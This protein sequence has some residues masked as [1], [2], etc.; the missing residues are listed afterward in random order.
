MTD[1]VKDYKRNPEEEE[2][3]GKPTAARF[4][5]GKIRH[6]L[7]PPWAI[8]EIAKVYT[9]GCK[10]YDDDNWRKGMKWKE[11]VIGPLE[12]HLNKWLRGE[13]IDDESNCHHLAMVIWQ[14]ICLMMYEKYDLGQDDRNPYDLDMMNRYEQNRRIEMWVDHAIKDTLD[15]YDGLKET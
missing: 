11:K 3:M 9:Y 7:I 6:D 15:E 5:K 8:E 13:K 10:K 4:S 12:R 14:C 2:Q 1:F